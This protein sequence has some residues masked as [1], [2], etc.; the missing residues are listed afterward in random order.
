MFAVHDLASTEE[1]AVIDY[2]HSC[3][4]DLIL[5]PHECGALLKK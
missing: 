1:C 4:K 5:R 3:L 2:L